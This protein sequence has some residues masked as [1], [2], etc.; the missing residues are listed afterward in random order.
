MD[1]NRIYYPIYSGLVVVNFKRIKR[2]NGYLVRWQWLDEALAEMLL[3]VCVHPFDVGVL[4]CRQAGRRDSQEVGTTT[5]SLCQSA[6]SVEFWHGRP[7]VV[8]RSAVDPD[9]HHDVPDRLRDVC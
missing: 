8:P 1:F 3:R 2:N 7:L 9:C 4:H 5:E 6:D